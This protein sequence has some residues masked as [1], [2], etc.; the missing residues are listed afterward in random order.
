MVSRRALRRDELGPG[1]GRSRLAGCKPW[2]PWLGQVALG[3]SCLGSARPDQAA[4]VDRRWA[5]WARGMAAEVR[6]GKPRSCLARDGLDC[7]GKSATVRLGTA[8]SVELVQ[9]TVSHG[10][11]G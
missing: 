11:H 4:K 7:C 5:R 8:C 2:L 10:C 9:A 1:L 6:K 3:V